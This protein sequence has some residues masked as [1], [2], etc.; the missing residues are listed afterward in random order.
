MSRD[1]FSFKEEWARSAG[2]MGSEK[3]RSYIWHIIYKDT[4]FQVLL[5]LSFL[6]RTLDCHRMSIYQP[7]I[8]SWTS[9]VTF[10]PLPHLQLLLP[11]GFQR[12]ESFK[13][14][15]KKSAD[16]VYTK[17]LRRL[18]WTFSFSKS[19]VFSNR[20]PV[21]QPLLSLM[22]LES[23][24]NCIFSLNTSCVHIS[25]HQHPR[26]PS[27]SHIW[28]SEPETDSQVYFRSKLTYMLSFYKE[29]P[30]MYILLQI[31]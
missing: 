1:D 29:D 13:N 9:P 2:I 28:Q 23:L 21:S 7:Q 4:A 27:T 26:S 3:M 18:I 17:S 14:A 11:S 30:E 8:L 25:C 19:M 20:H 24:R 16:T 12:W 6:F 10:L 31:V 22:F 15:F 5:L